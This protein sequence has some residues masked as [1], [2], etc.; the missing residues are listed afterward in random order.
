MRYLSKRGGSVQNAQQGTQEPSIGK[1]RS[2]AAYSRSAS[3]AAPTGNT[4]FSPNA[5]TADTRARDKRHK[6]GKHSRQRLF[7]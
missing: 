7:P 4:T 2:A 3:R 5:Q 6:T 1:S